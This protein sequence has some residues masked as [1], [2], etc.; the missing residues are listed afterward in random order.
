MLTRTAQF[1]TSNVIA[2]ASM[3]TTAHKSKPP[4]NQLLVF[5]YLGPDVCQFDSHTLTSSYWN[6]EVLLFDA[7][8]QRVSRVHVG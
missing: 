8:I 1:I 2:D 3:L 7:D 4:V 5:F 6:G